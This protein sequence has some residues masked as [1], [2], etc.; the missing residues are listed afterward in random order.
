M[1]G[2][3]K[4]ISVPTLLQD[5]TPYHNWNYTSRTADEKEVTDKSGQVEVIHLYY[6]APQPRLS[7]IPSW[8]NRMFHKGHEVF[9]QNFNR[10]LGLGQSWGMFWRVLMPYFSW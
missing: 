10:W 5:N 8:Q 4:A 6:C 2:G 9:V 3:N 7:E 1:S